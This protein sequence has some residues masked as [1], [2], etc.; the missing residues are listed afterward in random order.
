MTPSDI[1]YIKKRKDIEKLKMSEE[2]FSESMQQT[3]IENIFS[4]TAFPYSDRIT[5]EIERKISSY[6][7][8]DNLKKRFDANKFIKLQEVVALLYS[9]KLDCFYCK[10]KTFV[11]YEIVREMNQWTLDRIDNNVGHNS[12]NVVISCLECNL[13]RRLTNKDSFLFTKQLIINRF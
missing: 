11:M 13:K 8:Q 12:G 4:N 10:K 9:C 1:E 3:I 7:N 5:Q 2:Y 6:K